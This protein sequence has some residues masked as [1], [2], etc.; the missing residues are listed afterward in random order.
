MPPTPEDTR[1]TREQLVARAV[2]LQPLLRKHAATAET[3]RWQ[4][5]KVISAMTDAGLFRMLTPR[6]FGG[7]EADFRTI[8]E[9]TEAIAEADGSAAWV[10][11][12][13]LVGAWS[14]GLISAQAQQDIFGAD[15][16]ARIA[17]GSGLAPARRVN[18]GL[19]VSGRWAYSSGSNHAT[20]C[21]FTVTMVDAV[22]PDDAVLCLVPAD[23]VRMEDTW[24][25]VG[26]RGTGSNTWVADNVFVP[27]HRTISMAAMIEGTWSPTTNEPMY[28]LPF[29]PL[30]TLPI[31]GPLL[32]LGR[33][34]LELTV[35]NAPTKAMQYT[36]FT[37]QSDSVGVQVQVAEA[38]LR[39]D[40]ARLHAY[41]LA[42]ELDGA[43]ERGA[44]IDYGTRARL[45]AQSG[46]AAQQVLDAINILLNVHGSASFAEA[47]RLQQYWRDANTAARHAGIN[48]VVGYEVYGKS[49]LGVEERISPMV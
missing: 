47:S 44:M 33:A 45:R 34:S 29:V 20:W 31:L 36:I 2:A 16:D 7:Y 21:S 28:R 42:D 11:S 48:A 10:L 5:G 26:M 9:T 37:R 39:L 32:G 13:A 22:Q 19:R 41:Q 18:G 25:T 1:P 43:A 24:H 14:A 12:T 30:A 35:Q 40:T 4:A 27:Q 38:A 8:L 6:R 46:Y 17:G 23:D 49:L 15:P 3:N